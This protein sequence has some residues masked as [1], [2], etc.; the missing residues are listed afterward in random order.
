MADEIG[1]YFAR[2][3]LIVDKEDFN[4]GVR[5]LSMLEMEMKQT[6]DK[7]KVATNNWKEFVT[8][9]AASLYVIKQVAAAL[10]DMY[11]E[12]IPM[13]ALTVS[14]GFEWG[15]SSVDVQHVQNFAKNKGADPN[16]LVSALTEQHRKMD[17][18]SQGKLDESQVMSYH[19]LGLDWRQEM[20][21]NPTE[22][23]RDLM[24]GYMNNPTPA[25]AQNLQDMLGPGAV[26][27][28]Q[29]MLTAAP[30]YQKPTDIFNNNW[31]TAIKDTF[32]DDKSNKGAQS[33]YFTLAEATTILDS[34]KTLGISDLMGD[35]TPAITELNKFL[36]D[37]KEA[38]KLALANLA[39][40]LSDM[41][42]VLGY[43]SG[44]ILNLVLAT[45]KGSAS[46]KASGEMSS[47]EQRIQIANGAKTD[48]ALANAILFP[49]NSASIT[50]AAGKG[51]FN[52]EDIENYLLESLIVSKI[53]FEPN[54]N[55]AQTMLAEKYKSGA[56]P[57]FNFA[58]YAS[59]GLEA[60][61]GKLASEV[62]KA[63]EKVVN[64]A[65]Q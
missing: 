64:E 35:L 1:G 46:S 56:N 10:K 44:L 20:N 24:I 62:Q 32:T 8:G 54:L 58:I 30:P 33:G 50:N 48:N 17:L 41:L 15:Q 25:T 51:A 9:I 57:I 23:L 34:I 4:T 45:Q 55:K 47:L 53:A 38:I 3:R 12:Y 29:G 21:K 2:L 5:T 52:K 18:V 22:L 14:T 28:A 63:V 36:T 16:Q 39:R 11:N 49:I 61:A 42:G 6:S 37:N 65:G 27:I 43:I 31:N 13:A 19:F 26:K 40:I 7:T 59:G 60:Y